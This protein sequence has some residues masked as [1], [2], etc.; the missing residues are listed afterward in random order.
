MFN[1]GDK[2]VYPNQGVGIVDFIEEREF[3]GKV[4]S[5]YKIHL[6]NDTMQLMLPFS[7]VEKSN[8]R[9]VSDE[10]IIDYKLKHINEFTMDM[11]ELNSYNFKE[12]AIINSEKLKSGT[13]MDYIEVVSNL[14]KLKD[15]NKLNTNEKQILDS[16]KKVLIEEISQSKDI[17][18]SEATSLLDDSM[19]S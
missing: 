6:L 17:S 1:V 14:T 7:R 10:E 13:L 2:I 16:T 8:I 9:L 12:R 18:N 5:Y 11:D 19:N 3:K 15:Y 4:Q